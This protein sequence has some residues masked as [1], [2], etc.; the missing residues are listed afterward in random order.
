MPLQNVETLIHS[1]KPT[2][3]TTT[4]ISLILLQSHNALNTIYTKQQKPA[5]TTTLFCKQVRV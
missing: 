4:W 1:Q 3:I 5:Y 2:H